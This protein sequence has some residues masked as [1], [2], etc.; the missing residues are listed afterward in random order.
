MAFNIPK[1]VYILHKK[2]KVIQEKDK[3]GAWGHL[4]EC[5]IGIGLKNATNEK[6]LDL[7]LHE[8]N[9]S[10]MVEMGFRYDKDMEMNQMIFF[11][12]HNEFENYNKMLARALMPIIKGF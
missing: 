7:F 3:S 10:I 4:G 5:E 9:E 6:L 11:F 12:D 8:V 2:M 1:E